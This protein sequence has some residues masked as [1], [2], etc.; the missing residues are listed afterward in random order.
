M[1]NTNSL[2]TRKKKKKTDRAF[3]VRI[4]TELLIVCYTRQCRNVPFLWWST[5]RWIDS[6]VSR[7]LQRSHRS[8]TL[9]A[10]QRY[11]TPKCSG[12]HTRRKIIPSNTHLIFV[13][14]KYI[15]YD[16]YYFLFLQHLHVFRARIDKS[17]FPWLPS[18][19]NHVT[20]LP[21]KYRVDDTLKTLVSKLIFSFFLHIK[22][23]P[24]VLRTNCDSYII[25]N[26]YFQN[27]LQAVQ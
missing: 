6:F 8:I 7:M 24:T 10:L 19:S 9:I 3:V 22:Y 13:R 20:G 18:S 12:A 11:M 21:Y 17:V 14:M 15:L 23:W 2:N 4:H 16:G 5:N 27:S 25:I 26:L 1:V